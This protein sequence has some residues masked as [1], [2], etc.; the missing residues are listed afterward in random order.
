[1]ALLGVG[2]LTARQNAVLVDQ[3]MVRSTVP[4]RAAARRLAW[5]RVHLQPPRW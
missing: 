1:M 2:R 3:T 5:V 4:V